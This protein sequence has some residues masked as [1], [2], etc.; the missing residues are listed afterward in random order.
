[1]RGPAAAARRPAPPRRPRSRRR[2]RTAP[3][4]R[5]WRRQ[6]RPAWPAA[7]PRPRPPAA[8]RGRPPARGRG[9]GGLTA[10][11]RFLEQPWDLH[12]LARLVLGG[13]RLV[14][15]APTV[16]RLPRTAAVRA[17]GGREH[18][19]AQVLAADDHPV[20]RHAQEPA[21]VAAVVDGLDDEL[22]GLHLLPEGVEELGEA[23]GLVD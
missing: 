2:R 8:R 7:P 5:P 1:R 23:A 4:R 3:P 15:R 13:R 17:P 12:L 22:A 11:V 19:H 18:G 21:H 9:T 16:A 20:Q 14:R 6:G 10:P